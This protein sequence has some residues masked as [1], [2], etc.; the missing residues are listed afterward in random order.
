L[1]TAPQDGLVENVRFVPSGSYV[2]IKYN[3]LGP[4]NA[5]Y[6]VRLM[7]RRTTDE[8]YEYI[9]RDVSGD[10]GTGILPGKD[11]QIIW[12][13]RDEYPAGFKGDDFYFEIDAR[14]ISEETE[15]K[16]WVGAVIAVVGAAIVYYAT[17]LMTTNGHAK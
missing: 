5:T 12:G 17:N 16:P 15:I 7:L 14:K 10:V 11:R 1:T 8:S 2:T 4:K 9:P 6:A 3:L 13:I